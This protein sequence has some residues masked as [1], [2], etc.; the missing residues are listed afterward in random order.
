M[1]ERL[2]IPKECEVDRIF[3]DYNMTKEQVKQDVAN[4][5]KWMQ[6]QPYLPEFPESKNGNY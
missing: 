5:R 1:T 4:I 2:I 6:S 3:K